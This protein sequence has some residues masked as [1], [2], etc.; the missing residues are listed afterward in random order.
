MRE[1]DIEIYAVK[2]VRKLGGV[3]YKFTSPGRIGV[4]D[5]IMLFPNG[6]IYF[7]EFK[8]PGKKPTEG[9]LREHKRIRDLGFYVEVVDSK[10][11]VDHMLNRV[12]F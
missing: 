11:D 12:L 5:R 4:P 1:S 9:Q 7:V 3:A 8:A 10:E 6:I 2:E